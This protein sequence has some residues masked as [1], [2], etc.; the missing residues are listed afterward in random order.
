MTSTPTPAYRARYSPQQGGP[1]EV[2]RCAGEIAITARTL[3]RG[4]ENSEQTV[5]LGTLEYV[6]SPAMLSLRSAIVAR[7][8][9][10]EASAAGRGVWSTSIE[11]E[12][13]W[14]FGVVKPIDS[15]PPDRLRLAVT[16]LADSPARTIARHCHRA[17]HGLLVWHHFPFDPA[18]GPVDYPRLRG[19]LSACHTLQ[20]GE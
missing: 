7:R 1:R 3:P 10:D 14:A 19:N 9:E 2:M 16:A 12:Q 15:L 20:C 4:L 17:D 18:L 13:G 8:P 11:P 6:A 5:Q